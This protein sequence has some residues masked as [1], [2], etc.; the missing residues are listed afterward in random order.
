M[1]LNG[2]QYAKVV[3]YLTKYLSK[4]YTDPFWSGMLA[5]TRKREWGCSNRL[6]RDVEAWEEMTGSLPSWSVKTNSKCDTKWECVGML[7]RLLVTAILESR[8]GEPPLPDE[9][10]SEIGSIKGSARSMMDLY[11]NL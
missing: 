11:S 5:L 3:G 10:R 4:S 2:Q 8:K 6:M 1:C 7:D 9:L